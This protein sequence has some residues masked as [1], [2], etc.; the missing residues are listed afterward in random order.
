MVNVVHP[1]E[2][3]PEVM[4]EAVTTGEDFILNSV[5]N[6]TMVNTGGI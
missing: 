5:L 1:D 2:Q 3:K 4:A 6:G